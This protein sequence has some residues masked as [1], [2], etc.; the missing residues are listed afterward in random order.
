MDEVL[1]AIRE[2]G[3]FAVGA[4]EREFEM[5]NWQLISTVLEVGVL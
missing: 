2:T 1:S 4:P 3:I 5:W